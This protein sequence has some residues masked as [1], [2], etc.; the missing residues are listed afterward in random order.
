MSKIIPY[1]KLARQQH[2]NFLAHQAREFREREEYLAGLRK[3]LFKIEAQMRQAEMQQLEAFRQ[4]ADHFKIPL[5]F[6]SLG[7]RVALQ[8]LFAS[9]PLLVTL[10]EFFSGGLEPE[11]CLTRLL[12]LAGT[13]EEG[14]SED[15]GP[16]KK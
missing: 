4:V 8:E 6:P 5:E 2:L 13:P 3:L 11:A 10:Q 9:H 7:D 12:A 15:E 14:Q 1:S 16:P